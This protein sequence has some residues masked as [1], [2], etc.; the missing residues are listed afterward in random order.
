[1][2][3]TKTKGNKTKQKLASSIHHKRGEWFLKS[4]SYFLLDLK[5]INPRNELYAS[6]RKM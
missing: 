6:P 2:D 4:Y 3:K 5:I 1:M